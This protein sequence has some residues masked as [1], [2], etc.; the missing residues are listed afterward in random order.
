VLFDAAVV[1]PSVLRASL[2]RAVRSI[3]AQEFAGTVQILVGVDDAGAPRTIIDE[4]AAEC[5]Q[6]MDLRVLD[7]GYSTSSFRGG[8]YPNWSG[9]GLRTILSYA[10]NSRY[11]AYLDDDNWWAP[12]HLADLRAAIEGFDWAF[13]KR[14][15]VDPETLTPLCIDE[16]ESAGPGKGYYARRFGGFV[17]ANCLMLD[18]QACHWVLPAW[19]VPSNADKGSGVDRTIF[20]RLKARHS[21]AWT[22]NATA[23]YIFRDGYQRR[24]IERFVAMRTDFTPPP[25]FAYSSEPEPG[26]GG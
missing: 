15:Y 13:S 3:Y 10:A 19:C 24:L 5:P 26:F 21:V 20:V 17:D 8:A 4:L 18:K 22:G 16:W 1:I 9:G 12:T 11:L 23:F 6:G 14:W 7:L 2:R 25:E